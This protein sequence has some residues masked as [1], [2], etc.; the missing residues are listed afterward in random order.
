MLKSMHLQQRSIQKLHHLAPQ[1]GHL[2]LIRLSQ[3]LRLLK[4]ECGHQG[5]FFILRFLPGLTL[6]IRLLP[7]LIGVLPSILLLLTVD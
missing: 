7:D 1:A 6:K 3:L 4:V 5:L 2:M